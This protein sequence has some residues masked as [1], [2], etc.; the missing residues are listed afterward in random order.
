[1]LKIELEHEGLRYHVEA[2][3]DQS[4]LQSLQQLPLPLHKACRNGACGVCRCQL[5][6]GDIDYGYRAPTALWD[7]DIEAGMIL[8][9]I[10]TAQSDVRIRDIS[11][12]KRKSSAGQENR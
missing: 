2:L 12:D 3:P 7:R 6:E 1:V 10:A 5:I 4:L 9:C 11:L 8:P